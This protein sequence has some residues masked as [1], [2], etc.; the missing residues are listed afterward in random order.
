MGKLSGLMYVCHD[1]CM[2][3][4]R[5]VMS[6]GSFLCLVVEGRSRVARS[7]YRE[8]RRAG[9]GP[10]LSAFESLAMSTLW[11]ICGGCSIR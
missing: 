6:L 11:G 9:F 5:G 1:V 4:R 3:V 7:V 10:V 8:V 2:V